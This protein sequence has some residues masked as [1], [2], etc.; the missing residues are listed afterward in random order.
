MFPIISV[1]KLF[2]KTEKDKMVQKITPQI[3]AEV[4]IDDFFALTYS[5]V[6]VDCTV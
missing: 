1:V 3:E 4:A 6:N 2:I 5:E